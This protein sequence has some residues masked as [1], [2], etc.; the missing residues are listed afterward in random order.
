MLPLADL[1]RPI[2][3]TLYRH[4]RAYELARGKEYTM[5]PMDLTGRASGGR[6]LIAV[7]YIDMVG[8]SRLIGIDDTDTLS[9]LRTLRHGLID[10]AVNEYGGAIVQTAGDSFLIPFDSIDGAMR[11]AIKVQQNVPEYDGDC[12][13]IDGSAFGS[14][15]TLAT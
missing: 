12:L 1:P 5:S 9:R 4:R 14:V 10:P 15:S 6:K 11:C 7:A 13:P 2:A 3:G 8:Y